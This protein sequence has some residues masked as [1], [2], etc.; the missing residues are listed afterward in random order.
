MYSIFAYIW[1]IYEVNLGES[2][3]E[4]MSHWS[5]EIGSSKKLLRQQQ[6]HACDQGAAWSIRW[7]D[8]M[9][10]GARLGGLNLDFEH[11]E[12]HSWNWSRNW[13]T[14]ILQTSSNPSKIWNSCTVCVC[15]LRSFAAWV[16][17]SHKRPPVSCSSCHVHVL[18]NP[19]Q[20]EFRKTLH[21]DC[22]HAI[23]R[24]ITIYY[25]CCWVKSDESTLPNRHF[26][27]WNAKR[28]MLSKPSSPFLNQSPE[29][30]WCFQLGNH[31]STVQCNMYIYIYNQQ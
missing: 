30:V 3:M 19:P 4:H 8:H 15:F 23:S 20:C 22:N 16:H 2:Y 31:G 5:L 28:L 11:N 1:M 7:R 6:H 13:S 17:H 21:W 12:E 9:H 10:L 27:G 29:S 26:A 14:L 25:S 18:L 24:R